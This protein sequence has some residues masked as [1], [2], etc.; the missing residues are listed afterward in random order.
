MLKLIIVSLMVICDRIRGG[1]FP[2]FHKFRLICQFGYGALVAY[3]LNAPLLLI[4]IA[5]VLFWLGEKPSWRDFFN[6]VSRLAPEQPY[7]FAR[8]MLRGFIWGILPALLALPQY[9]YYKEFPS[10]IGFLF[11]S[12]AFPLSAYIGYRWIDFKDKHEAVELI[13]P[14][15]LGLMI[16][17]FGSGSV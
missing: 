12:L 8:G 16:I 13:R 11:M 3:L 6:E 9:F 7:L 1:G 4:P 5:A 17:L 10:L 14:L 2:K 15:L